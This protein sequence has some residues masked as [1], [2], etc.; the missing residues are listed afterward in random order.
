MKNLIFADLDNSLIFTKKRIK[1]FDKNI[2]KQFTKGQTNESYIHKNTLLILENILKYSKSE[3][4]IVTS[5]NLKSYKK[6]YFYLED[7]WR[8]KIKYVINN[9][10]KDIYKGYNL[11]KDNNYI[12]NYDQKLYLKYLNNFL[13]FVKNKSQIFLEIKNYKLIEDTYVEFKFEDNKQHI[14]NV[15][16]DL[17]S[18]Q[19]PNKFSIYESQ[20]TLSFY[21][22]PL[23]KAKAVKYIIENEPNGFYIGIGDSLA[24]KDFLG[25]M[26]LKI[27]P[28]NN[29]FNI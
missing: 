28:E 23:N 9:F 8:K 24:D 22:K 14:K 21:P 17:M 16:K 15:L 29:Q 25:V 18:N 20:H 7:M 5:R 27:L 13:N 6:T 10:G 26:N 1:N 3:L 12:I 19:F 4:I 2:W 11:L